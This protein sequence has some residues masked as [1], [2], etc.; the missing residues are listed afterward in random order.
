[1]P[2]DYQDREHSSEL[3]V[4]AK[5]QGV[6]DPDEFDYGQDVEDFAEFLETEQE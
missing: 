3:F 1:M 6:W 5:R 4:D 2:V